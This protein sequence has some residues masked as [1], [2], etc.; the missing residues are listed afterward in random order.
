MPPGAGSPRTPG[1]G[2]PRTPSQASPPG[3]PRQATQDIQRRKDAHVA[4]CRVCA[5]EVIYHLSGDEA[6][7]RRLLGVV[8]GAWRRPLLEALRDFADE[9]HEDPRVRRLALE[10]L[11][12]LVMDPKSR[13][14][15][16]MD[17]HGRHALIHAAGP[18]ESMDIRSLVLS[19]ICCGLSMPN[20][21]LSLWSDAPARASLVKSIGDADYS[22][23]DLQ[24]ALAA[25]A[26]VVADASTRE[27]SRADPLVLGLLLDLVEGQHL[28]RI[29]N[30][31]NYGAEALW[32]LAH[33]GPNQLPMVQEPRVRA[34]VA[35]LMTDESATL[36]SRHHVCDMLR[37]CDGDPRARE[38]VIADAEIRNSIA[39]LFQRRE[40]PLKML[41]LPTLTQLLLTKSARI[42]LT[43]D[44][45]LYHALCR[46]YHDAPSSDVRLQVL[47]IFRI[48]AK[49]EE[50]T[51]W[52]WQTLEV[53]ELLC[54]EAQ[55]G[56]PKPIV[57][58]A[59]TV[60][61][62]LAEDYTNQI[63]LWQNTGSRYR[64]LWAADLETGLPAEI[65][66]Y[67]M[68]ALERLASNPLNHKGMWR[69]SLLRNALLQAR[70][71]PPRP[72]EPWP[73]PCDV[74][75]HAVSAFRH[76]SEPVPS[77][78]DTRERREDK[79][80]SLVGIWNHKEA[81][82]FLLDAATLVHPRDWYARNFAYC[83][84]M[85]ISR[86][87]ANKAQMWRHDRCRELLLSASVNQQDADASDI[88]S[89]SIHTLRSI[90]EATVVKFLVW[91]DPRAR[92]A[93]MSS[94]IADNSQQ[95]SLP[96]GSG[97]PRGGRRVFSPSPRTPNLQ[98][99]P[100][101]GLAAPRKGA[102]MLSSAGAQARGVRASPAR[103]VA[104]SEA[105]T[106]TR[107]VAA[108]RSRPG[109][110]QSA[111]SDPSLRSERSVGAER[112]ASAARAPK[113]TFG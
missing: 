33:H 66:Q 46:C 71:L 80:R 17:E 95:Q 40:D 1:A 73:S 2:T 79:E 14:L 35:H 96:P 61:C 77:D 4:E 25:L 53:Q 49:D 63:S 54:A 68:R 101:V 11:L 5:A 45:S 20:V 42:E 50:I 104:V 84:L 62:E 44:T 34:A 85:N 9:P 89:Y 41:V 107:S 91:K 72:Q 57:N 102:A 81:L 13:T 92:D 29:P 65:W 111:R 43:L 86:A 103:S 18:E 83:A 23:E 70:T 47:S 110:P 31:V 88:R 58:S 94:A 3:T 82:D 37:L 24:N 26:S 99:Q 30:A 56:K 76:L 36:E 27:V 112:G 19:G 78:L 108:S 28:D 16:L 75:T 55:A 74:R 87:A 39:T 38:V 48:L 113:R 64:L 6:C 105:S 52:L 109:S 12:R 100:P 15:V 59:V 69:E 67:A 60:L 32:N 10:V 106:A 90:S 21:R 51:T 22:A 98:S 93:M 97:S 8:W 7:R